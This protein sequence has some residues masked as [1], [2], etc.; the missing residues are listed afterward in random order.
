MTERELTTPKDGRIVYT[1]RWW[2]VTT[3]GEV[4][5]FKHFTSPQCNRNK[6]VI[7]SIVG[8]QT[9]FPGLTVKHVPVAFIPH[10]CADYI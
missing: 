5:F 1:D 2:A 3:S 7:E 9:E 4:L 10:N 8:Q 6:S